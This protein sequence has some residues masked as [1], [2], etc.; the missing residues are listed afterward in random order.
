MINMY[1]EPGRSLLSDAGAWGRRAFLSQTSTAPAAPATP[2]APAASAGPPAAYQG[3]YPS[4]RC[5]L[6]LPARSVFIGGALDW[7]PSQVN[8]RTPNKIKGFARKIREDL[9]YCLASFAN[10]GGDPSEFPDDLLRV[11]VGPRLPLTK[12]L[13]EIGGRNQWKMIRELCDLP[14]WDAE[15]RDFVVELSQKVELS[16]VSSS[17]EEEEDDADSS[18][19]QPGTD[20]HGTDDEVVESEKEGEPQNGS[21]DLTPFTF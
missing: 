5:S 2:G 1:P 13:L 18:E 3:Y 7:L 19:Y 17:E 15:G 14:V 8:V 21:Q 20:Q 9:W 11:K 12:K 16:D 6:C 10:P 4:S